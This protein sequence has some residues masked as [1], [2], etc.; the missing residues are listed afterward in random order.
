MYCN[1][2]NSPERIFFVKQKLFKYICSAVISSLFLSANSSFAV[3][4]EHSFEKG[5]VN[6]FESRDFVSLLKNNKSEVLKK[7]RSKLVIDSKEL[8]LFKEDIQ[9]HAVDVID[10]LQLA[11][12]EAYIV[13]GA[14]RDLLSGKNPKDYDV[15]TNASADDV[16]KLFRGSRKLGKNYP[17]VRI[18]FDDEVIE[19]APFSSANSQ[20]SNVLK[21]SLSENDP[22]LPTALALDSDRRDITINAIYFDINNSQLI[23]FHGGIYDLRAHVIN[24]IGDAATIYK[25]DP[26][27]MLRVLRFAAKLNFTISEEA[28]YPILDLAP[29]LSKVHPMRM[30]AEV[31][32]LLLSGHSVESYKLLNKY[33]VFK[34]L[35]PGLDAKAENPQYSAYLKDVVEFLD[36]DYVH[37]ILDKP[38]VMFAYMLWPAFSEKFNYLQNNFGEFSQDQVADWACSKVLSEQG[39]ATALRNTLPDDIRAL[40]K[41]QLQLVNTK[42]IRNVVGL[43]SD[44]SFINAFGL[45]R[46]RSLSDKSIKRSVKFWQPYYDEKIM[47]TSKTY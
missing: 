17:I 40:W 22:S 29:Y 9:S 45:L 28:S 36:D 35:F 31:N 33:D 5:V 24:T 3:T 46:L 43:S 11:G 37:G 1:L 42:D 13:G 20:N 32:K 21:S 14:V 10:T 26:V 6:L 30:Y 15:C 16:V 25:Q 39:K 41:M 27:R 47:L 44:P 7:G 19:V 2:G 8:D 4:H 18:D 23:D 38:Y 12:F 34:Y